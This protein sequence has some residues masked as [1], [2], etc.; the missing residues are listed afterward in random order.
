[1]LRPRQLPVK[2][3]N[4]LLVDPGHDGFLSSVT[5]T[6]IHGHDMVMQLRRWG[7]DRCNIAMEYI[8]VY[9]LAIASEETLIYRATKDSSDDQ[10]PRGTTGRSQLCGHVGILTIS[11]SMR[12]NCV[13]RS[14]LRMQQ[15][16]LH[17]PS[18]ACNNPFSHRPLY[19]PN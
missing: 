9:S 2:Q 7:D 3:A 18:G 4:G 1:M 12:S 16:Y 15:R 17:V 14:S 5:I 13:Q 19:G 11:S 6:S 8:P 10:T